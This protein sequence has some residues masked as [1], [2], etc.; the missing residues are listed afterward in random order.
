MEFGIYRDNLIVCLTPSHAIIVSHV[1]SRE[2]RSR[3][4]YG[5]CH[6]L[7]VGLVPTV[8]R[9]L[10]SYTRSFFRAREARGGLR[11]RSGRRNADGA[12]VLFLKKENSLRPDAIKSDDLGELQVVEHITA[13]TESH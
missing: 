11:F 9:F 1:V 8:S 2:I 3:I 10:V 7:F 6:L 5:Q 4:N 12:V 13:R